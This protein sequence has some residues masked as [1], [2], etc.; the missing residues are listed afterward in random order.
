MK[1]FRVRQS[2]LIE[3]NAWVSIEA[4][5]EQEAIIK[6][7]TLQWDEFEQR[8]AID[9][10]RWN[11]DNQQNDKSLFEKFLSFFTG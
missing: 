2:H 5:D 11:I 6:A 1:T 10:T 3:K 8:E 9:Q 4:S 7:R